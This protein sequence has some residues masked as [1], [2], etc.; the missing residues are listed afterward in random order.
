[1][2]VCVFICLFI[3]YINQLATPWGRFLTMASLGL[4]Y[5]FLLSA[6]S[7]LMVVLSVVYLWFSVFVMYVFTNIYI[8]IYLNACSKQTASSELSLHLNCLSIRIHRCGVCASQCSTLN[9]LSHYC[10]RCLGDELCVYIYM[11]NSMYI[12]I[13]PFN[14]F[15]LKP[16]SFCQ[17]LYAVLC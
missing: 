14:M 1:M 3:G 17:Y 6:L 12:L 4:V 9:E 11:Y 5:Y 2:S 7:F 13:C 15:Q 8:C 16:M 10:C